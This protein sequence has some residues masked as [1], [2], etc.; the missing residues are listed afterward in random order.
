MAAEI[1][2]WRG[3]FKTRKERVGLG[4]CMYVYIYIYGIIVIIHS[5]SIRI[6]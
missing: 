2:G 5:G 1:H 3:D 4:L 6:E